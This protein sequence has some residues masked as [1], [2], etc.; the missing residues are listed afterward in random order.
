MSAAI[1]GTDFDQTRISLSLIRATLAASEVVAKRDCGDA[2][3]TQT[4]ALQERRCLGILHG[5]LLCSGV[6]YGRDLDPCILLFPDPCSMIS[7]GSDLCSRIV[8]GS[9]PSMFF[10]WLGPS[11]GILHNLHRGSLRGLYGHG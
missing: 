4:Q 6:R 10:R 2:A 5:L 1:C 3:L 9:G 8:H 11:W 7:L